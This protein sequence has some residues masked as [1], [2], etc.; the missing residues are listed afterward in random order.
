MAAEAGALAEQVASLAKSTGSAESA[1]TLLLEMKRLEHLCEIAK[2][3]N[4]VYFLDPQG[5][6]PS[7]VPVTDMF[8]K[9]E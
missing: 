3:V 6:Y 4:R 7:T 1:Q 2:G 9:K 5:N 8:V